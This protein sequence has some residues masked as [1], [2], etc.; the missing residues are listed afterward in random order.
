MNGRIFKISDCPVYLK[1]LESPEQCE[2]ADDGYHGVENLILDEA[3]NLQYTYSKTNGEQKIELDL[4]IVHDQRRPTELIQ[5]FV[6]IENL[7][8]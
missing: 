4:V 8:K 6:F 2:E 1:Q 7:T 5:L 3:G